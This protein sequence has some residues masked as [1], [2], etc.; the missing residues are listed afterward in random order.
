MDDKLIEELE[1]Y[2]V[3]M[4]KELGGKT[5]TL[6]IAA[7]AAAAGRADNERIAKLETVTQRLDRNLDLA[8]AGKP[9]RDLAET[10]AELAAALG[11]EQDQ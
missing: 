4:P 2:K 10:K 9:V 8:I 3:T 11:K 5:I 6:P 7:K 1:G